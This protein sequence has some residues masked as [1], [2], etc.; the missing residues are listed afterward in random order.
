MK[1][2]NGNEFTPTEMYRLI[3]ML[4]TTSNKDGWTWSVNELW[5]TLQV[6]F[7]N[8]NG[9]RIGDAVCHSG[10]YGHEEGLLEIMGLEDD[11]DDVVGWLTAGEVMERLYRKGEL[12]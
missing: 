6:I 7:Y 4:I 1:D 9:E 11:S 12:K 2:F 5:G 10:S 8:K 3:N